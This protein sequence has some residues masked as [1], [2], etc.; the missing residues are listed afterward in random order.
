MTGLRFSIMRGV[1]DLV[2]SLRSRVCS[3][4]LV[5]SI[6]CSPAV[7]DGC[8]RQSGPKRCSICGA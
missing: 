6:E 1:N 7:S 2:T 5:L 8:L 3:G 4:P